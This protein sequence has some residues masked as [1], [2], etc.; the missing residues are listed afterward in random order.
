MPGVKGNSGGKKGRSGRKSKAEEMGLKALLDKCFTQADRETLIKNLVKEARRA[1]LM[2]MEAAKLLLA[3]TF[4]KPVEK[5]EL[6]GSEGEALFE[7]LAK[8]IEKVYGAGE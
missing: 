1:P 5:H 8:A 4:G 6:T 3:Y 2:N 7:P